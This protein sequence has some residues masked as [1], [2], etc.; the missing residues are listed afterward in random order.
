MTQAPSAGT[1]GA[2]V[3]NHQV[4]NAPPSTGFEVSRRDRVDPDAFA[5]GPLLCQVSCQAER[6]AAGCDCHAL[7]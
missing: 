3:G 4:S 6:V 1:L 5:G 2:R 7:G